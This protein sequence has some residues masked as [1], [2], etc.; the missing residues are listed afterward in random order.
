LPVKRA[1][2]FVG[3]RVGLGA[4]CAGGRFLHSSSSSSSSGRR[5]TRGMSPERRGCKQTAARHS[6]GRCTS[7]LVTNCCNQVQM[8]LQLQ[9]PLLQ[10][11][12]PAK[13]SRCALRVLPMRAMSAVICPRIAYKAHTT[14]R[15]A[16]PAATTCVPAV[17]T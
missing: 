3:R 1:R 9:F 11:M 2:R 8:V 7:R 15:A 14:G 6:E 4:G 13:Q 12:R 16:D 10:R 17:L 5:T